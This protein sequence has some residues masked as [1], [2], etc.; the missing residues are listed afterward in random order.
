MTP[1]ILAISACRHRDLWR[2]L[3]PQ[4]CSKEQAAF[5]FCVQRVE[6]DRVIFETVDV[7]LLGAGDFSVQDDDYL[8]LTDHCRV[9]LIKRAHELR[10]TLVELHSHPHADSAVFSRSDRIGL[11][12]TVS[13]M[14]WRLKGRPYVAAVVTPSGYDALVWTH[15][16]DSPRRLGGIRA[17]ETLYEPENASLSEWNMD[18]DE[19]FDRNEKLFGKI[20]QRI[21]R[22]TRVAV[23]GVGGLG[24]HVVQQLSLLGVGALDLIDHEELDATNRNRYIGSW[25][26][27][28]I[29]GSRKVDLG[30]RHA[31]LIDPDMRVSVV[32][33]RFP[34]RAAL[35]AVRN[36]DYVFGCVHS[37][38]TRFILN[39]SCLAYRKPLFDLA[40]DVPEPGCYGG[41][42]AFVGHSNGCLHCRDVLD[43]DEV[44]RD[45]SPEGIATNEID[46]YGI[47]HRVLGE[48]GPS[49]VSVNGV[50]ASLGVTEFM[51]AVTGMRDPY[52]YVEYRGHQGTVGRRLAE[53]ADDC[54]L[55]GSVK[56]SGDA[57]NIDRYYSSVAR[58]G[59]A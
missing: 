36:A 14:R 50:V 19:R 43:A 9:R 7:A 11:K 57:A 30:C 46:A 22:R 55:C 51:A 20:G 28:R 24:T 16:T 37:D 44:R 31:Y 59:P 10:A 40:S 35:E 26:S 6:G 13:H 3:L 38:G 5:M 21:L 58:L 33:E 17:G 4:D 27:D 34:S 12:E 53:P 47:D 54:Y 2:H 23:V 52:D 18:D 41:R 42:V 56:G 8:E 1:P 49:V 32:P 15:E 29:P 25:Y 48:S 45:L 39:E